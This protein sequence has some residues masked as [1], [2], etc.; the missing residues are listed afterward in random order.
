M[1]R[2]MVL[3]VLPGGRAARRRVKKHQTKKACHWWFN[4]QL[5]PPNTHTWYILACR[6]GSLVGVPWRH[7]INSSTWYTA[8][9]LLLYAFFSFGKVMSYKCWRSC[10]TL[11]NGKRINNI[12]TVTSRRP[13]TSD[14]DVLLPTAAA[15]TTEPRGPEKD[16]ESWSIH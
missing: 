11:S 7:T 2:N 8:A 4:L 3:P 16:I 15:A 12:N 5:E 14:M 9:V 13:P 10:C 6:R 1:G